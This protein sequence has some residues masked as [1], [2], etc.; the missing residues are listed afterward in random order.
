MTKADALTHVQHAVEAE[1]HFVR[2]HF[3]DRMNLRGMFWPDVLA[4]VESP[5]GVRTDGAD[6]YGRSR[7]FFKGMTTA[8]SEVELLC[9][10]EGDGTGSVTFWTIYW[11]D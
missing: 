4:V 5:A 9:V 11:D 3:Y 7:W 6:E 2:D 8:Q 10:F 1:N